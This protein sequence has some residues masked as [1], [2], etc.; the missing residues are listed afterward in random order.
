MEKAVALGAFDGTV[1]LYTV[2]RAKHVP[3]GTTFVLP[4]L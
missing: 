3:L 2:R 1:C 4:A